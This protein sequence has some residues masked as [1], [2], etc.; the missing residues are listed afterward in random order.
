LEW[1]LANLNLRIQATQAE[2]N[3]L[4]ER[5]ASQAKK[6]S[7]WER[8]ERAVGERDYLLW[9]CSIRK[10]TA[11][12][13]LF[14]RAVN[15]AFTEFARKVAEAMQPHLAAFSRLSE[16]AGLSSKAIQRLMREGEASRKPGPWQMFAPAAVGI[17]PLGLSEFRQARR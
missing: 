8:L 4:Y 1:R 9:Q 11:D 15:H 6:K 10:K 12:W 5:G 16:A 14:M 3:R 2:L 13:E 7:A 17:G